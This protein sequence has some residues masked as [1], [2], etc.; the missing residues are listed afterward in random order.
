MQTEAMNQT[1]NEHVCPYQMAFIL[2]NWFRKLIQKPGKIVGNYIN[3]GDTVIDVGCGPGFFSIDMARMVGKTGKVIAADL[4]PQMLEKVKKKALKHG[5]S[6][7]MEFHQCQ[8]VSIGLD[9]KAD[10][11]LGYYMIHETGNPRS[12]LA[13]MSQALKTGGKLLIVEP[14][15]HVNQRLFET[16]IAEARDVGLKVVDY[17]KGKGGR[18]VLFT[19]S[20]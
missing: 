8:S 2:D 19:I 17:P 10:F 16:M 15:M 1:Q 5:V 3:E 13:E 11:I 6:E 4:Q 20:E 7:R 12:F 14:R 9:C 18:S